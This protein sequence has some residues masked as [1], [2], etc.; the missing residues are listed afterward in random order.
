MKFA[1]KTR[2]MGLPYSENF[3]ILSSAAF[4]WISHPCDGREGGR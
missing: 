3:M 4:V 1:S 2:G